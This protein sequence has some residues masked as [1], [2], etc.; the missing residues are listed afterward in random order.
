MFALRSAFGPGLALMLSVSQASSSD[1]AGAVKIGTQAVAQQEVESALRACEKNASELEPSACID[2]YFVPRWLLS[3]EAAAQNLKDE[4]AVRHERQDLLHQALVAS[5]SASTQPSA[6]QIS[7]F[8]NKHQRD[9]EKPLRIRIFRL[10]FSDQASAEATLRELVAGTNIEAFR[11]LARE[12]SI[13][14]ATKERGGDLGF[15]WPDG[16][17]D[18]PQVSAETALYQ[19]ALPLKDGEICPHVVKEGKRF[20]VLWRR[21]SLPEIPRA[22]FAD[23]VARARV[24]EAE[25][26]AQLKMLLASLKQNVSQRQSILLGKLRRKEATLF[27]EP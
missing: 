21:G 15:V 2:S 6:A 10:L 24:K 25:V 12:R 23:D 20:A 18:V 4:P 5:V 11:K 7:A 26:E 1:L 8:Q 27:R 17:T 13:D 22:S 19:A 9:F 3:A 14:H 16:S